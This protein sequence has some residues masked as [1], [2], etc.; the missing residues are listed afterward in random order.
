MKVCLPVR[1]L[2]KHKTEAS[3]PHCS[4]RNEGAVKLRLKDSAR[5]D[6]RRSYSFPEGIDA[7]SAIVPELRRLVLSRPG[8]LHF[9]RGNADLGLA[10][11][12]SQ[13]TGGRIYAKHGFR[14]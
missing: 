4:Y 9:K 10:A 8:L 7:V 5:I 13:C 12:L 14:S 3:L 2:A 1:H 11:K 6:A